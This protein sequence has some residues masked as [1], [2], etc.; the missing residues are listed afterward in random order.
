METQTE[1]AKLP[2]PMAIATKVALK[3]VKF[4]GRVNTDLL[5]VLCT[6]EVFI[7]DQ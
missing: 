7:V 5:M 3:M 1:K 6:R 4:M 2:F